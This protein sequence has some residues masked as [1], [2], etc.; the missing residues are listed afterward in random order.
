M[1]GESAGVVVFGRDVNP[2]GDVVV[3][4]SDFLGAPIDGGIFSSMEALEDN[5]LGD[6]DSLL[7][8]HE[9][10]PAD[11]DSRTDDSFV[12]GVAGI[13]GVWMRCLN[14]PLTVPP[15]GLCAPT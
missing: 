14:G 2:D 12:V 11:K 7:G 13:L 1:G 8:D 3:V 6:N 9:P 10:L 4:G 5:R 15:S